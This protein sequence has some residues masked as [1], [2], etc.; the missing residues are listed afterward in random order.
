MN[1]YKSKITYLLTEIERSCPK[2]YM[3][4]MEKPFFVN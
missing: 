2:I 4:K 1:F 3:F